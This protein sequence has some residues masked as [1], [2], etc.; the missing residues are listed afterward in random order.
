[1]WSC[2]SLFC[3]ENVV[4]NI[5]ACVFQASSSGA[6]IQDN[7][8]AFELLVYLE[9]CHAFSLNDLLFY[10]F[11]IADKSHAQKKTQTNKQSFNL[12]LYT[13]SNECRDM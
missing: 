9:K 7:Q 2:I 5:K 3:N 6:Y 10:I 11:L 8:G 12:P 4:T 13:L 1:M